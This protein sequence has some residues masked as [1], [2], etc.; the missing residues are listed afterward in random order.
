MRKES[1]QER[2]LLG[3]AIR[4]WA[5]LCCGMSFQLECTGF[6]ISIVDT[7]VSLC[8]IS[9]SLRSHKQ[10]Y[11][12]LEKLEYT[13]T[14]RHNILTLIANRNSVMRGSALIRRGISSMERS[15]VLTSPFSTSGPGSVRWI[16]DAS[17][18][19]VLIRANLQT[20]RKSRNEI[21]FWAS[22]ELRVCSETIQR[23]L[24]QS[25]W[26]PIG[27]SSKVGPHKRKPRT[28]RGMGESHT[29]RWKSVSK[30][31]TQDTRYWLKFLILQVRWAWAAPSTN[32]RYRSWG[33]VLPK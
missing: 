6:C 9:C 1:Y 11:Q 17:R 13:Q 14:T 25:E 4:R 22:L 16:V 30:W 27:F 15:C 10:I 28:N 12:T 19:A 5:I 32:K 3:E 33:L 24:K 26:K 2:Y 31:T 21:I 29:R 8:W 18:N 23:K 7:A 20:S